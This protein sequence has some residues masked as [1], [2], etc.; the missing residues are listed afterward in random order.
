M[1]LSCLSLYHIPQGMEYWVLG[2]FCF[3][4]LFV[5]FVCLINWSTLLFQKSI[6]IISVRCSILTFWLLWIDCMGLNISLM[7][8]WLIMS[9]AYIHLFL[10][11][12]HTLF[13]DFSQEPRTML[14]QKQVAR[15]LCVKASVALYF[16]RKRTKYQTWK[17]IYLFWVLGPSVSNRIQYSSHQSVMKSKWNNE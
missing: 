14:A 6:W 13:A 17:V 1:L 16:A 8:D 4:F 11:E 10:P 12:E 3:L 5:C 9:T 15:H 2:A 7:I